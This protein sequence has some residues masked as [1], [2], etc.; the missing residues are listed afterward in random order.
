MKKHLWILFISYLFIS[1]GLNAT[2]APTNF[3]YKRLSIEDGLSQSR[4]Q[5]MLYDYKG[6]L[7]IGT[8][9]GLNCYDRDELKQYFHEPENDASLISSNICFI[10]EDALNNLWIGT[11]EGLC[12]FNRATFSFERF[13]FQDKPLYASSYYLA[14]DGVLFG[15][16]GDFYKYDYKSGEIQ[17]LPVH[18]NNRYYTRFWDLNRLNDSVYYIRT[19][20]AIYSYNISTN[21]LSK[22]DYMPEGN[23]TALFIDSRSQVWVSQYGEGLCCY[24]GGKLIKRFTTDNSQ[25]TYNVILDIIEKDNAIWV[26]TDGGG[27]NIISLEDFSFSHLKR[28]QDDVTSFPAD[29]VLSL[30][31]DH[32]NNMWAGSIRGGLI[33]IKKVYA[34]SYSYVPFS[35]KYGL[36]NQTINCC[37]QD[38]EGKIWLGTD[39]GGVNCYDPKVEEFRHFANSRYE[40]VTAIIEYS[41]EELLISSFDKGVFYFNKQTGKLRPFVI[42]N[43]EDNRKI[44][45]SSFSVNL[46]RINQRKIMINAIDIYVYDI[47]TKEFEKIASQGKDYTRYAP[48]IKEAMDGEIYL[49]DFHNVYQYEQHRDTFFMIYEGTQEIMDMCID[50]NGNL[51]LGCTDGLYC[52]N[53]YSGEKK[54]IQTNLFDGVNSLVVDHENRI[55]IGARNNLL[56]SYNISTNTFALLGESDGVSSNEYIFDAM[57]VSQ[58]GDIYIGGILGMTKINHAIQF[59]NQSQTAIE[60]ADVFLNGVPV[61]ENIKQEDST[62]SIPWNFSSLQ[63]KVLV[64]E[65]D[66]FRKDIFRYTIH[67]MGR[68]ETIQSFKHSFVIN[69]LPDGDYFISVSH[70]NKNGEWSQPVEVLHLVINPPYWRTIWFIVLYVFILIGIIAGI[71]FRIYRSKR[72]RQLQEIGQLKE[73][74][75]EDKIHF[76]INISHELRTPLTLI[77]APL[78][79]LLDHNLSVADLKGELSDI[80]KQA[81]QMK[82]IIN[83]VLDI[84][85]LEE[86]KERLHITPNN[87]NEW[88]YNVVSGFQREAKSKGI[89]IEYNPDKMIETVE[90]DLHKC[91][92]IL[93][94]LL[95]NALKFSESNTVITIKTLLKQDINR[96]RIE[97]KDQGIGLGDDDPHKLFNRFYQG[98]HEKSGSG[99][100]LSYSKALIELHGGEIGAKNNENGGACFFFE[101]PLHTATGYLTALENSSKIH[102][103]DNNNI[104]E[105]EI[106]KSYSLL[107]VEDTDDLRR[108]LKSSMLEYFAHTYVAK[109]GKQAF[110]L[111]GQ[112]MP[113]IIVSDVMMPR[114]NGFELCSAIKKDINISHI[115]VILLTAYSHTDNMSIGYKL[116]AD[117][118]IAKPFEMD[119]LLSLIVNQLKLRNSI[120]EKYKNNQNVSLQDITFSNADEAFLKRLNEFL[121]EHLAEEKLDVAFIST[122]I[123]VSR[124]L[125]FNKI[126]ALTGMGIIDY[127][128]K[129]RIDKAAHLLIHSSMNITEISE[130]VGFSTP[131]YFSKVFK[132]MKE[133]TPSAYRDK[134]G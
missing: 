90:F 79:R 18:I 44:C 81:Q 92:F 126:K 85:K 132:D 43:E 83:M 103:E 96:V 5:C 33:G 67:G 36:S 77:C 1:V 13:T 95:M 17:S 82:N 69:S 66:V 127:V 72:K 122:H 119:I 19:Q 16:I 109:D 68:N 111:I 53:K 11:T 74:I 99:I 89:A 39:G 54:K 22:P 3:C 112:R 117:A 6:Y 97:V 20:V 23:Y 94:N 84:R 50:I 100:G 27:I 78:K 76:L 41:K 80:Y 65:N 121:N 26:A 123:G 60:L 104:T 48:L 28:I 24:A 42:L 34:R 47:Q 120:K 105:W 59:D 46:K 134:E 110:E 49:M 113:D 51:W 30:Y 63:L 62:L 38:S 58:E 133:M 107:I 37:F 130:M 35:N 10:A 87:L 131:R 8:Q 116:G 14:D 91:E 88:V 12:R 15:G 86:G 9:N 57:S 124:S 56:F 114:M 98:K 55:W 70:I 75:Y 129:L 118:F 102:V 21:E 29:A 128:N 32:N 40:K 7:W 31:K 108:Y 93:S 25:L 125:L 73:K 2:N 45:M 4:V 64:N 71:S 115:P 106:L 101:L 61:R 52:F